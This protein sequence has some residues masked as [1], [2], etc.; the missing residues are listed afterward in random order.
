M[1]WAKTDEE[2]KQER[3]IDFVARTRAIDKLEYV[4]D[5]SAF[6]KQTQSRHS[7]IMNTPFSPDEDILFDI[8]NAE[9]FH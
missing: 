1:K 3:N 8:D 6:K 9:D 7:E 2:I 4:T 5:W